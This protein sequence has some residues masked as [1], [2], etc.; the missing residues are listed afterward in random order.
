MAKVYFVFGAHNHQPV[1]NFD[2]VFEEAYERCYFPFLSVLEQFPKIKCSIHNS[3]SLYDWIIENRPEYL[4]ILKRLVNRKQVEITS[5]AYYEPILPL[6]LD[7]DKKGQIQLMNEFVKKEFK[8]IPQGMWLAERV[9]EPYL[10]RFLND[11]GIKYTFLDDT[12]FRYAGLREKEFF[13]YYTTEDEAKPVSVFPISKTLRYQI[14]FSQAHEAVDTLKSFAKDTDVLV[15]LFDDG[16]KFGLWP[17]TY[18]W[19]YDKG[20]LRNFFSLLQEAPEIETINPQE[21]IKKF[22]SQGMVYLPTASYE[23]MG[24]WVL[25]PDAFS[26][27]EKFMHYLQTVGKRE[28]FQDFIRGGFF[29]YFY[30]KYPRLNYMHKRMLSVS[31]KVHSASKD[32]NTL[33]SL[34]KAQTNCSYWHGIFGGFYLGHIRAAVYKNLTDAQNSL[35][36]KKEISIEE[37]DID[38]D[39]IPELLVKNKNIICSLSSRGGTILEMSLRDFSWNIIDTISR[40][41]ESYHTKITNNV[42]TKPSEIAT[43]HDVVTQKDKDL[44][45]YLV[46]DGYERLGLVDHILEKDISLDSFNKQQGVR[47]LANNSYLTSFKKTKEKA[48]I[49]FQCKDNGLD[50]IKR[51]EI[52]GECG[53][54]AIYEFNKRNALK[55]CNFGIEFNLSLPSPNDIFRKE[56]TDTTALNEPRH[57]EGVSSFTILDSFKGA[58]LEFK[59]GRADVLTLPLY[60]VSS[61][62][63]GFEKV[64]QQL[65]VLFV[66]KDKKDKF[67]LS[68]NIKKAK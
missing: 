30:C 45:K 25:E 11:C 46:Y 14:P 13:G 24:E 63:T 28:E 26:C 21:A 1:G 35:D 4:D 34:W 57:W 20:W 64:Y 17:H 51:I 41:P 27:Y 68:L 19:V 55:N 66:V 53:F 32:K 59:C 42:E 39:G 15:T 6:I 36:K 44:D 31:K 10:A 49:R 3:G 62:E 50:F 56:H 67:K 33:T 8:S 7:E 54:D 29:R 12:H 60:S 5:G 43:I 40:R 37:E 48:S 16:E 9:W 23:E 18:D 52:A 2:H 61:S 38:L 22:S 58:Q 65:I 47:T